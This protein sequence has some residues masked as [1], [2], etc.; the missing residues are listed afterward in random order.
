MHNPTTPARDVSAPLLAKALDDIRTIV[1]SRLHTKAHKL[2]RIQDI[3]EAVDTV[4]SITG[5]TP[6]DRI[7]EDRGTVPEYSM[8]T[9][10]GVLGLRAERDADPVS[11]RKAME[12]QFRDTDQPFNPDFD[13]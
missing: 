4:Q 13:L 2:R 7:V 6:F 9:V 8:D 5:D 3:L 12:R 10:A 1:A 11:A